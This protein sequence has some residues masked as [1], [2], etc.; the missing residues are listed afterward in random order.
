M[1]DILRDDF[2]DDGTNTDDKMD[3]ILLPRVEKEEPSDEEID[4]KPI[5]SENGEGKNISTKSGIKD[6]IVTSANK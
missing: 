5:I 4:K 1:K 3:P 2:I 6:I